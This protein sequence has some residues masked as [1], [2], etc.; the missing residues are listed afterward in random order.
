MVGHRADPIAIDLMAERGIDISEHC[1]VSLNL[2]HVRTAQIVFVMTQQQRRRIEAIYP[3][4][5]GKV[6][7]LGEHERVD[8]TDP[9]RKNRSIFETSL[10]E[11]ERGV[12]RW[13]NMM[14]RLID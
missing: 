14:T 5:K 1:A 10:A 2:E 7:C 12:D 11:I 8:I 13:L 9:Y 6:Y 3:Y 4:L